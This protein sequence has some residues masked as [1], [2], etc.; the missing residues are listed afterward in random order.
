MGGTT[1]LGFWLAVTAV[2]VTPPST[3][4]TGGTTIPSETGDTG[5]PAETGDTGI[6][7]PSL[8]LDDDSDGW[9][10]REGDCD[11]AD[12]EANPGIVEVCFDEIDNDCDGLYDQEC[13]AAPRLASLRG[14]GGCTGG[15]GVGGTTGA[16]FLFPPLL[17]AL[18]RRSA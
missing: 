11:D 6:D 12:P 4:D 17:T 9:T 8:D 18:R 5:A 15:S 10:P 14:G 16:V 7:D 3:G 13:D 1:V 2:A